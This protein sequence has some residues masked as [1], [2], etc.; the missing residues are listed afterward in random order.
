MKKLEYLQTIQGQL[1][2]RLL[3]FVKRGRF[4][5]NEEPKSKNSIKKHNKQSFRS[6]ILEQLRIQK[7]RAYRGD[8]ILRIDFVVTERNAPAIHTLPKN[9]LDLLHKQLPEI[10]GYKEILF[11]DDNQIKILIVNYRIEIGGKQ[12]SINIETQSLGDF[13]KDLE[14][15]NSLE[16]EDEN[17]Y[18]HDLET[19][20]DGVSTLEEIK[21]NLGEN[22]L[23]IKKYWLRNVQESFLKAHNLKIFSLVSLFRQRFSSY[24]KYSAMD[25]F[26]KFIE[27]NERLITFA[28]NFLDFGNAPTK[29]GDKQVFKEGV[30]DELNKFREKY[31]ILFPLLH[32]IRVNVLFIPPKSLVVDLDNLARYIVPFVN[33][34]FNPPV[35]LKSYFE[36]EPSPANESFKDSKPSQPNSISG[37]HIIYIP[38]KETDDEN[39]QI[40]FV[41]SEGIF[42]SD[43]WTE[44]DEIIDRF[45]G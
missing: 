23:N 45:K 28:T 22:Y 13:I 2:S 12:G 39:G 21:D 27:G 11:K 30:R 15:I 1:N 3:R 29:P 20:L 10:D 17:T 44:M 38:R 40:L 42:S 9:Y 43:L 19:S 31:K 7:K 16:F 35:D 25:D 6:E 34:V 41:I 4:I 18:S 32:P 24:K 8:L 26:K 14:L 36:K 37:Y 5:I 33:E